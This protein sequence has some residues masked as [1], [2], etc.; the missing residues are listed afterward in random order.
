MNKIEILK[1]DYTKE[2]LL[3]LT[4][5][6][7]T[8]FRFIELLDV[9]I[10]E[11]QNDE[12]L[13]II[14]TALG[15]L[16]GLAV[17]EWTAIAGGGLSGWLISKLFKK[18]NYFL[19]LFLV[20]N[21]KYSFTTNEENKDRYFISIKNLFNNFLK[22]EFSKYIII[23]DNW[24]LNINNINS[25]NYIAFSEIFTNFNFSLHQVAEYQIKKETLVSPDNKNLIKN[26]LDTYYSADLT[27][28]KNN[29]EYIKNNLDNKNLEGL[30]V[31]QKKA[32]LTDDDSTLINAGAGSGKTKT[33]LHKISY[34]LD[35]KKIK[36]EEILIL[37]YNRNVK[38]E[39]IDRIIKFKNNY[40]KKEFKKIADKS[41]YTF[42]GY[43]ARQLKG[44]KKAK[45]DEKISSFESELR[46]KK[47][48]EIDKI[49]SILS[50]KKDF[51][52]N[53]LNY[54]SEY[55]YSYKDYFKDIKNFDDYEKYIRNIGQITLSGIPMRSY[56]EVEIANYLFIN[57]IKFEYE[58]EYEG[59]YIY[60]STKA[61]FSLKEK[62]HLKNLNEKKYRP[63]FYLSDYQIYIEHFALNKN[64]EAPNFFKNP[65]GYYQQYLEKIQVHKNNNTKLITTFSW[66][67]SDGIL[68]KNLEKKL[69]ENNVKFKKLTDNEI[70]EIFKKSGKLNRFTELVST[71]LSHYKSNET[72]TE[73]IKNKILFISGENNKR[74]CLIFLKLFEEIF[75]EYQNNL[76]NNNEIDFDDMIIKGK[77]KLQD[78][79][80]KY[81]IVDEFQDISQG[82]A[83]FL[84]RL[85]EVN[86]AKLYCVGDDWQS[87][88]QFSG[89][90]VTIFSKDFT[91]IFGFCERVD[92]DKTFRY[93]KLLNKIS[94]KFIQKNPSQL[95]KIVE[96]INDIV[97]SNI[98]FYDKNIF[99]EVIK[100]LISEKNKKIFI[101][102]RYN[103]DKYDINLRKKFFKSNIVTNYEIK[104]LIKKNKTYI[105]YKTIHGSKGLEAD[106]VCVINMFPGKYGFPSQMEN[107]EILFLVLPNPENFP[108][109][110]ERRLMYV[111]MTRAK[112][113][114]HLFSG[115]QFYTS[116]FIKELKEDYKINNVNTKIEY[117]ISNDRIRYCPQHKIKLVRRSS[118]KGI[119]Y[120]CPK[121]F[122]LEKCKYT[123]NIN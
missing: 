44:N 48:K 30:I 76:K 17:G 86:N 1:I 93:G 24:K 8:N 53:L 26:Y 114:L 21:S 116:D 117:Q 12:K 84:K 43:G 27:R 13:E 55:F 63:D 96:P 111:A 82:R 7:Q 81:I 52:D 70:I 64:N 90:D 99:S 29:H 67:K 35:S 85:Q 23:T 31:S 50:D 4:E 115:N 66:E 16:V 73:I 22:Q 68:I 59:N 91:K 10:Q 32:V 112:K 5:N 109:A 62:N 103:L 123:E 95:K 38:D 74:R 94:S 80:Y 39:L 69:T 71:F 6:K 15:S 58:K 49:I 42:H 45:F 36:P 104:D 106:I 56:E 3:V 11:F 119:F 122:S 47:G 75:T 78:E 113:E 121:F 98:F 40:L 105:E 14:F 61:D 100:K 72:T 18:K 92:I 28:K 57:G 79:K 101:L 77:E 51:K 102:G 60:N 107:D 33:I 110:E 120:A 97:D 9:E 89:G 118:Y 25:K 83:N 88:N 87:I 20:N 54:F 34:L 19:T 46:I 108:N 2:E 37:A 65:T 41:I